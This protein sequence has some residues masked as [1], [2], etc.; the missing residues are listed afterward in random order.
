MEEQRSLCTGRAAHNLAGHVST[1]TDSEHVK[2]QQSIHMAFYFSY[3]V[4]QRTR[5]LSHVRIQTRR[6]GGGGGQPIRAA[7][8]V[9]APS[10]LKNI[11]VAL[12]C[13]Q[14]RQLA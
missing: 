11:P 6:V 12:H 8:K 1:A 7:C 3:F 2:S 13:C 5:E 14:G 10:L 4:L 9:P